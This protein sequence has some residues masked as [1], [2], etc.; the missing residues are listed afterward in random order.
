MKKRLYAILLLIVA[1]MLVACGGGPGG[2]PAAAEPTASSSGTEVEETGETAV[3]SDTPQ[4]AA[5]L[6]VYNWA[7]YIDETLLTKYQEEYGVR[8]IYDTFASNEDLLAKLQAGATGY[9]V[10]VPS[11][12]MVFQMIELGLLA[13]IDTAQLPN[14]ANIGDDFKNAPF[15]PGNKHCVPYQAGTSGIAYEANHPYFVENPPTSWSYL[16]DPALLEQYAGDGINVLNDPRELMAAALVYLGYDGNTTNPDEIAAA[17]DV[18]VKAKPYYKTFNSED[19]DDTLLIAGEVALSHSWSGDA[20][21]AYWSTYND[22]TET[23]EWAYA[24]PTEGAVKWLDSLCITAS[25]QKKE[26]ALHF[27]NYLLDAENGAAITNFTYYAS[28]NEAAKAY[29]LDEILNDTSIYPPA[30]VQAKLYWLQDVGDA[31]FLYDEAWTAI[32]GQ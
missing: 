17:R 11:D 3:S 27:I 31:V 18:I 32:K 25:S 1:L 8:I 12:Y 7:D 13:E 19:Y 26:T 9:D 16:F 22:E 6:S 30:E 21:N 2:G 23:S 20:A 24:I 10:I 28:P 14:F 5:E 15:D 4:L 29:I